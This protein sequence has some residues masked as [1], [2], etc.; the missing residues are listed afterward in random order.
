MQFV[1]FYELY[2][3]HDLHTYIHNVKNINLKIAY[4][5]SI[6]FFFSYVRV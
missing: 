5:A 3:D 6:Q 4:I 2:N 1:G